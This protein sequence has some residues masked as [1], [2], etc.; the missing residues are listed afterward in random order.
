M[1]YRELLEDALLHHASQLTGSAI[2][3]TERTRLLN[4]LRPCK[5]AWALDQMVRFP[6]AGSTFFVEGESKELVAR[7]VWLTPREILWEGLDGYPGIS[8]LRQGYF[9]FAGDATGSGDQF[10]LRCESMQD[11]RV[12]R[13]CHDFVNIETDQIADDGI[14]VI[15]P[16]LT[17]LFQFARP[18][19]SG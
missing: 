5:A 19:S 6:L 1:S 11:R 7:L 9:P 3:D 12:F 17:L 2:S 15:L 16:D 8:A 13:I 18:W 14:E 4:G 10:F